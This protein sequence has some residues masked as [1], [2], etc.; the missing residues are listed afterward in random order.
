MQSIRFS[1]RYT[2]MPRKISGTFI[3]NVEVNYLEKLDPE[4]IKKDT[5]IRGGG[6][7]PL[8]ETGKV[9]IIWLWT[10]DTN[11]TKSHRWQTIR[12]WTEQKEK[13]YKKLVG[14]E[15]RI[16]INSFP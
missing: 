15:V 5:A 7:Y 14:E 12:P 16:I 13:Y 6:H 8:P 10:P 4:F 2:K 3:E 1:H 9:I 11:F